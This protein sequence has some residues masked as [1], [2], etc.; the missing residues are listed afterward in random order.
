MKNEWILNDTQK[1]LNLDFWKKLRKWLK[2]DQNYF[3]K[4]ELILNHFAYQL[5]RE[6]LVF[7]LD[8]LDKDNKNGLDEIK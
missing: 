6:V 4:D 7:D 5:V 8:K 3:Y 2:N 1:T